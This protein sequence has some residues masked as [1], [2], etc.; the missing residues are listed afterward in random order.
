MCVVIRKIKDID[1]SAAHGGDG[2]KKELIT[3]KDISNPHFDIL[4]KD[5]LLKGHFFDWHEHKDADEIAIVLE[6]KGIY[7]YKDEYHTK[8][9]MKND[10]I[11]VNA[12]E[13]HR[14][15]AQ[16]NS[17]FYFIRIKS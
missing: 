15:E 14:I 10:V 17:M 16:E 3:N 7:R 13:L 5:Y 4:N 1:F 8:D 6:G 2:R 9:Y 11:L 12:G